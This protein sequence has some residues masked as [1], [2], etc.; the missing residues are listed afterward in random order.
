[1]GKIGLASATLLNQRLEQ[2]AISRRLLVL[3]PAQPDP[4]LGRICASP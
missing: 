4:F 2:L 3:G 1:M